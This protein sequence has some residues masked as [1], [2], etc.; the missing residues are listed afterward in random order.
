M[1]IKNTYFDDY[2]L[3]SSLYCHEHHS[4]VRTQRLS[5]I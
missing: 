3:R 4:K 2:C 5:V 1:Y